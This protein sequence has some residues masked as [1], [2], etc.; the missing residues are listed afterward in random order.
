MKPA[1][2]IRSII[3]PDYGFEGYFS[4]YWRFN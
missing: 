2:R 3:A 4:F 1:Y